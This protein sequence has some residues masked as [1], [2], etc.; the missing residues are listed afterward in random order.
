[1]MRTEHEFTEKM[2]ELSW[3]E[4]EINEILEM[5]AKARKKGIT[6]PPLESFILGEFH[7]YYGNNSNKKQAMH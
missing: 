4:K 3:T 6:P 1:M 7:Q 2:K 5:R